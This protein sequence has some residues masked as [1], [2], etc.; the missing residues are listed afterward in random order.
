MTFSNTYQN[1]L[2]ASGALLV[3]LQDFSNS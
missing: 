1:S 3:S 2:K